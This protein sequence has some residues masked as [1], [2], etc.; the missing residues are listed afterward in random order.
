ME[1]EGENV[2]EGLVGEHVRF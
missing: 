1:K 2:A